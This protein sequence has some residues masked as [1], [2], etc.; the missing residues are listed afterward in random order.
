VPKV[1]NNDRVEVE[2][3]QCCGRR[4]S[5]TTPSMIGWCRH[6]SDNELEKGA[7]V[8][9]DCGVEASTL[10]LLHSSG[11]MSRQRRPS[12]FRDYGGWL[13]S[14]HYSCSDVAQG[15]NGHNGL[16]RRRAHLAGL[17]IY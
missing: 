3:S 12:L 13:C 6:G 4:R 14:M 2:L 10:N 9:V 5:A 11:S 8:R 16:R 15:K 7:I 17:F 1:E